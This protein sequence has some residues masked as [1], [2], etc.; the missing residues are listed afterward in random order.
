MRE[1][2]RQHRSW[3]FRLKHDYQDDLRH[4]L[5]SVRYVCLSGPPAVIQKRLASRTGHF[6]N[7]APLPSQFEIRKPPGRYPG[8]CAWDSRGDRC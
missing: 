4:H 3:L 7:P 1:S 2:W 6:M 5:D 8:G